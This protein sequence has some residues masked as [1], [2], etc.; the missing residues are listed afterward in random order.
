MV[1]IDMCYREVC[2]GGGCNNK[3]LVYDEPNMVTTDGQSVVGV[4]TGVTAE[5]A[6]T[7]S[8]NVR[9]CTPDYCQNGGT[10]QT[11]DWD[12]IRY[13]LGAAGYPYCIYVKAHK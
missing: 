7:V 4:K 2:E 13:R 10:C 12:V 1:G 9:S 11:N 3:L 5:C 6:C 8:T